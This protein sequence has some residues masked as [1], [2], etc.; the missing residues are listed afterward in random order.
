[1]SSEAQPAVDLQ[2]APGE[3][4]VIED[5]AHAVG[6]FG[7]CAETL[8]RLR[9]Q[10][11]FVCFGLHAGEDVGGDEAWCYGACTNAVSRQLASPDHGHRRDTGFGG[12]VIALT[13]IAMSGNAGDADDDAAIAEH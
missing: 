12:A 2:A 10:R 7:G 3:K 1:M 6:N 11:L 8:H 5:D 9:R 13:G 4:I